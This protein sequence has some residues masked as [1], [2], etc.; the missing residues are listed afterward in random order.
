MTYQVTI[1][2]R[3]SE[4]SVVYERVKHIWWNRYGVL[5]VSVLRSLDAPEHDYWE[6]PR[7]MIDHVKI[8]KV[9]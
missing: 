1:Y 4:S 9:P 3:D 8:Q 7:E 2:R 6:W 5:I